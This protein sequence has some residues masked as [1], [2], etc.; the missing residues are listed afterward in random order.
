MASAKISI[1]IIPTKILSSLPRARTDASPT[2]P[3]AY[4]AASEESPQQIPEARCE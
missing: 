3:I 1:S 2:T 4:P